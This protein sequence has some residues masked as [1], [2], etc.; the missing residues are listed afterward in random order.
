MNAQEFIIGFLKEWC[1]QFP[2]LRVKYAY[3]ESSGYHIVEILPESLFKDPTFRNEVF[4]KWIAF[5]KNCTEADL[6]ISEPD[7]GYDMSNCL[8]T[9]IP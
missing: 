2:E 5:N 3:E 6:L 8:F 9:N 7:P 1:E 4:H